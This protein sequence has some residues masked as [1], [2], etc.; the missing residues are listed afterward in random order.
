MAKKAETTSAKATTATTEKKESKSIDLQKFLGE[1][2][3]KAYEIYLERQAKG[4]H[5][6]EFSDWAQAEKEVKKKYKI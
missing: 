4:T 2:E 5:G 6:D 1:V 3:K